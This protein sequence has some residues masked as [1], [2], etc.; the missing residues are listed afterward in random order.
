MYGRKHVT[1]CELFEGS[2]T[3][4]AF[5]HSLGLIGGPTF[6]DAQGFDAGDPVLGDAK[7]LLDWRDGI[8]DVMTYCDRQWISGL[9]L[10]DHP[11][12]ALRG[13][14]RELPRLRSAHRAFARRGR[15][16]D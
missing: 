12:Q 2:A 8:A 3:D 14:P 5:P 11:R 4:G 7:N 9:Q 13:G 6:G 15:P 1:G 16:R 10:R